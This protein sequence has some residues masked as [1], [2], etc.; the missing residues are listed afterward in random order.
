LRSPSLVQVLNSQ[1]LEAES[2]AILLGKE[3]T[4]DDLVFSYPDGRPLDP[5]TVTHT[6]SKVLKEAG[7]PHLRFHDLRHSHA[8]FLLGAGVN[9]KVVSERLGHASVAFTLDTYAHVMPG[10]QESAAEEL[11]RFLL[12]GILGSENVVRMLAKRLAKRGISSVSRTGL[13]PVTG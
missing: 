9:V 10:M 12:P 2:N 13:E 6:F 4:L 1:R 5:S 7:L 3:L 8:S 11:D